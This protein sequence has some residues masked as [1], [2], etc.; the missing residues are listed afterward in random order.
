M[1]FTVEYHIEARNLGEVV[2]NNLKAEA[3]ERLRKLMKGHS[4]I[5]GAAVALTEPAERTTS[6]LYRA[7]VVVYARPEQIAAVSEEETPQAA[8]K[9]ALTAV[10]RQVREKRDRLRETL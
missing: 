4:D 1:G 6:F 2:E 3:E 9:G 10:E 8:L 5:T 7:R